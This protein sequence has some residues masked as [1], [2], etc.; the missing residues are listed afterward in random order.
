MAAA[1][2]AIGTGV[3][4]GE[5]IKILHTSLKSF[6][7][8]TLA[9]TFHHTPEIQPTKQI[10]RGNSLFQFLKEENVSLADGFCFKGGFYPT[11]GFLADIK[12]LVLVVKDNVIK[13]E[14]YFYRV[15]LQTEQYALFRSQQRHRQRKPRHI[16]VCPLYHHVGVVRK[17][18]QK[19]VK[20][21][22]KTKGMSGRPT[23]TEAPYGY[24]KAPD[25]KEFWIFDEEAAEVVRLIFRLFLDGKN[26]DT[27]ER[28]DHCCGVIFQSNRHR[29]ILRQAAGI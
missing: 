20:T 8:E 13:Y 3:C 11:K 29:S 14:K 12:K 21:G 16:G 23:A 15:D 28:A 6:K 7:D 19:K 4:F 2:T 5:K 22:I 1:G 25:N 26:Y 24:I 9:Y 17:G 10:S 27:E 18:H